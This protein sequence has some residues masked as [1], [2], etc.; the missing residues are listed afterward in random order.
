MFRC[1]LL[2]GQRIGVRQTAARHST[3]VHHLLKSGVDWSTIAHWLGHASL[4]TT[5]HYVTVDLELKRK[6]LARA[7][8][9]RSSPR[10]RRPPRGAVTPAPWS[11]SRRCEARSVMW[12]YRRRLRSCSRSVLH[13]TA[14]SP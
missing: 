13:I 3:A 5:T 9:S 14:C 11:G 4:N 12:S 2:E 7:E 6:A 10:G 8:P 1:L